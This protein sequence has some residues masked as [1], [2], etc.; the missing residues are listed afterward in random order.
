MRTIYWGPFVYSAERSPSGA[1]K[2]RKFVNLRAKKSACWA[3]FK[4]RRYQGVNSSESGF[5]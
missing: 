3:D 4:N 2:P 1:M 5:A